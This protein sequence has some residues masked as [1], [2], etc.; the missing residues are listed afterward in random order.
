MVELGD[1]LPVSRNWY[2]NVPYEDLAYYLDAGYH[3]VGDA[4]GHAG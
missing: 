1:P 2:N 4:A 3:T